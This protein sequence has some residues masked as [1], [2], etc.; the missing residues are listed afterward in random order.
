MEINVT[1]FVAGANPRAYSASQME[2]GRDAGRITWNNAKGAATG[3]LLD[4]PAKRNAFR[5]HVEGYGAWNRF[6]IN[7]WSQV[8]CEALLIQMISGD[9]RE[10]GVETDWT[11]DDWHKAQARDSWPGSLYMGDDGEI[12]YYLGI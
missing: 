1:A 2:L 12:Y 3:E 10:G 4:T 11:A 7:S 8:E 6:Q 9:M 5:D